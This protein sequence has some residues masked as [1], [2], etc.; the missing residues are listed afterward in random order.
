MKNFKICDV[1]FVKTNINNGY[2]KY[3]LVKFVPQDNLYFVIDN[4]RIQ[5]SFY[6]NRFDIFL[7]DK[8]LKSNNKK[9]PV[10][11][12]NKLNQIGI[13]GKK[14]ENAGQLLSDN[15]KIFL[16]QDIIK[17]SKSLNDLEEHVELLKLFE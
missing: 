16:R 1:N 13:V 5:N 12:G 9:K 17:I 8:V 6:I 15:L 7:L 4:N 2:K 3:D 14:V 11:D 10:I